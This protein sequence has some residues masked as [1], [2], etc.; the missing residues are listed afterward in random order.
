[1][2][3]VYKQFPCPSDAAGVEVVVEVL[4][5]NYNY[6]EVG[7]TTS[8]PSGY[9]S[10][11]FEP[12]VP[13]KYTVYVTFA[14]SEAYYGSFAETAVKVESAPAATPAPTPT[15]APMTD[16]YVMGFGIGIIVAIIVVGLLLFLM[17]RK[18]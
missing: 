7:R 8:D 13:G 12:E 1:M 14:G 9:Y 15:P 17:L 3:Y 5:S 11:D 2:L 18:R 10:V 16:T 6:Y 4:D